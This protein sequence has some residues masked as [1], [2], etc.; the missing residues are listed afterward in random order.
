MATKEIHMGNIIRDE[1]KKQGRTVTWFA[2]SIPCDR[3]SVYRIFNNPSIDLL[4]L[5]RISKIL[6]HNFLE[7]CSFNLP[8]FNNEIT[9][10]DLE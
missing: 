2:K 7:D 1:L 6:N 9:D 8:F 4:L 10:L 5:I 3:S